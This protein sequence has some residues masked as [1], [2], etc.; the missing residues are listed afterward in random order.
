LEEQ[1]PNDE[2]RKRIEFRKRFLRIIFD[3]T[4]GY[5]D[6]FIIMNNVVED[7]DTKNSDDL[8][9]IEGFHAKKWEIESLLKYFRGEGLVSGSPSKWLL[10]SKGLHEVERGFPTIDPKPEMDRQIENLFSS[11]VGER[12]EALKALEA[13]DKIDKDHQDLENA[14]IILKS[15]FDKIHKNHIEDE[16]FGALVKEFLDSNPYTKSARLLY[17]ILF[18]PKFKELGL[19][20]RLSFRKKKQ[21]PLLGDAIDEQDK[22]Q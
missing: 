9:Y 4:E 8:L 18:H 13:F 12:D 11:L 14:F 7:Y 1:A 3:I 22:N 2:F 6:K 16:D 17:R 21:L 19:A 20:K 15:E 5:S 10:T